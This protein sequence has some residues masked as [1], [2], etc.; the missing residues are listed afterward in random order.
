MD[1]DLTFLWI[2]VIFILLK[3]V[4]LLILNLDLFNNFGSVA[5]IILLPF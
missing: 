2:V 3:S 5:K 1:T 4:D